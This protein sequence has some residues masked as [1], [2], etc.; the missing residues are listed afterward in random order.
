MILCSPYLSS[1]RGIAA[2]MVFGYGR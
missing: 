1:I 2:H